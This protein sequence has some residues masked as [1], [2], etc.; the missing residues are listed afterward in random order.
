MTRRTLIGVAVASTFGWT[1][2]V[3]ASNHQTNWI[4]AGE[5][6]YPPMVMFEGCIAERSPWSRR[7][8]MKALEAR[9]RTPE[10]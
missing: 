7:R 8:D 4:A 5:E 9:R 10:P 3:H 6:Q 1:A 2:A